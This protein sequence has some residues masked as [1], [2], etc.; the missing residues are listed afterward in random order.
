MITE[1]EIARLGIRNQA[2]PMFTELAVVDWIALVFAAVLLAA[3]IAAVVLAYITSSHG[4]LPALST[5]RNRGVAHSQRDSI[6]GDVS[7]SK[8][9]ESTSAT[10]RARATAL[11]P[12][13]I[14]ENMRRTPQHARTQVLAVSDKGAPSLIP[15]AADS[16]ANPAVADGDRRLAERAARLRGRPVP[17]EASSLL[18]KTRLQQVATNR[19]PA[20]AETLTASASSVRASGVAANFDT[21]EGFK[22]RNPGFFDDPLGRHELRYWD[23]HAWTEYV[24]EHGER[25]TDPL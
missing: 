20:H 14:P 15:S 4:Q 18:H 5:L 13:P 21:T 11:T 7:L 1:S 6:D 24:K 3:A 10:R 16:A 23:G 9:E 12:P 22:A 25:F 2:F 17:E 8:P 19:T